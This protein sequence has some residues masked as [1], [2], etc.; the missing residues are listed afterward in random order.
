L[1]WCLQTIVPLRDATDDWTVVT[2][3]QMILDPVAVI[4]HLADRLDLP[5]PTVL[6]DRVTIPSSSTRKS[7]RE[8]QLIVK[9]GPSS[10]RR[11]LVDKWR[12]RVN[13]TEERAAMSILERFG[14]DI[15]ASGDALPHERFWIGTA[16]HRDARCT[17]GND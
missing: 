2:Y 1:S 5:D 14:L 17:V 3:E 15:Y 6:L 16:A 7:D 4:S 9:S 10:L 8:T 12:A 13:E 11:S